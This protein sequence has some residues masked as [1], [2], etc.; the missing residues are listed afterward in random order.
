MRTGLISEIHG[1]LESLQRV[2]DALKEA[3]DCIACGGDLVEKGSQG[4]AL[5]NKLE[6]LNIP[7]VRGNHDDNVLRQ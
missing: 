3:V 2:L 4:D 5:V 1:D 7:C 6:S